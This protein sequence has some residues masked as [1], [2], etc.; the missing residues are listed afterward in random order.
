MIMSTE[1]SG[2]SMWISYQRQY[3][4]EYLR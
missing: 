4:R 3:H 1:I 2:D